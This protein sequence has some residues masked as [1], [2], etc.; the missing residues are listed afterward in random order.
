[1]FPVSVMTGPNPR[2]PFTYLNH[3]YIYF[4]IAHIYLKFLKRACIHKRAHS[5]TH[6]HT[7]IHTYTHTHARTSIP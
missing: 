2:K 6:T 1:M 5:H 3:S 4:S 7:Y